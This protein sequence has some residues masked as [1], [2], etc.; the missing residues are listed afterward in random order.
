[1]PGANGVGNGVVDG[2]VV[3]GSVALAEEV[4]LDGSVSAAEPLPVDLVQVVRLEDERA[5]DALAG[6]GPGGDGDLAEHD[7]LR[8]ADGG[9]ISGRIDDK[10]GAVRGV[11]H[12]GG[13]GESPETVG[14]LG[15]VG[16]QG[17]AKSCVGRASWRASERSVNDG[18]RLFRAMSTYSSP[19]D[20]RR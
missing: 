18:T 17:G 1:M 10:F 6:G 15:E 2:A 3:A 14:A 4:A 12:L 5:H 13:I 7:V 11:G 19:E 16:G 9:C 8:G 20:C